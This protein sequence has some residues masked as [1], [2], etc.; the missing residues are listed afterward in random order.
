MS[1]I[2]RIRIVSGRHLRSAML[3]PGLVVLASTAVSLT[4]VA[5]AQAAQPRTVDGKVVSGGQPVKGA[6]VHLKDTRTL[7][8]KSYITAED[9]TYR[10]AQLS[11]TSDYEVWAESNGKKS[12]TKTISSFD[13]KSSFN[14]TLKVD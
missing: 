8:Q 6:V 12:S 13:N 7:A 10:F 5:H 3:L 2:R 1:L 14:Y 9:G 4:P 11:S